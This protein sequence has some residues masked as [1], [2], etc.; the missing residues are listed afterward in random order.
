MHGKW[1]Y[2]YR[3]IDHDGSLVDALL[4]KTRDMEAVKRFFRQAVSVYGHAA[5][6][7][8]TD[9]H[10]SYPRAR[11]ETKGSHVQHRTSTYLNTRL[12]QDHRGVK[13]RYYPMHGFGNFDSAACFCRA[14]D[15]L[16]NDLRSRSTLGKPTSLLEQRRA[17]L[18]RIAALKEAIQAIS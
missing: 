5:E 7:V 9:G 3:A 16:R 13:Q 17:F 11:R 12:E 1:C 6:Q 15:E 4:S 14:F 18:D 10:A 2:L 8:T